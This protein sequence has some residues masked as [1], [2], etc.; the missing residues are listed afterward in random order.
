MNDLLMILQWASPAIAG[1]V[2]WFGGRY[3]RR[4]D[5]LQKMQETID[6]LVQK[7][8]EL[9]NEVMLLRQDNV[10][11]KTGQAQLRNENALLRKQL[12]NIKR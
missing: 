2:G 4:T 3:G 6:Q 11:L 8:Q 1:I 7:N 12:E 5:S 10:E 9:Y